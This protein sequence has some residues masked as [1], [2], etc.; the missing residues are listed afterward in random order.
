M[1][2]R[3]F[4]DMITIGNYIYFSE[5]TAPLLSMRNSV[6]FFCPETG[7]NQLYGKE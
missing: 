6:G 3:P 4:I 1:L 7:E 2:N 5:P